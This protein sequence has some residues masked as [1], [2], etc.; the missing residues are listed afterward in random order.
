[1][2]SPIYFFSTLQIDNSFLFLILNLVQAFFTTFGADQ[3]C[4]MCLIL[5]CGETY[6]STHFG[7]LIDGKKEMISQTSSF[8]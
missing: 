1:M 3:S 2:L 6:P 5:A 7:S 8:S 4:A